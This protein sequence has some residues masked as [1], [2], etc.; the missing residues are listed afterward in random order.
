MQLRFNDCELDLQA[1][2]FRR[3]GQVIALEPQ[4]FELLALLVR[5]PD[6]LVDRDRIMQAV[7]N[8]RIVSD[9]AVSSRINAVRRAIGDDGRRQEML[10]TVPRLGFRFIAD[11]QPSTAEIPAT[12][13]SETQQI[14]M[15]R[16][17]DGAVLAYATTGSGPPLMRAGHFLTHVEQE[18]HSPV[19]RPLLDRL[20]QDFTL[21]RYDQ[22]CTGLSEQHPTG[23]RLD[24]FVEDMEAVA[25]AANLTRF[26]I[27]A[28]SQ[29]V[30]IALAFAA[31]H[32]EMVSALVL[33]GGYA[34][35]RLARSDPEELAHAEAVMT[36]MKHGWG[37]QG[38]AF[39]TAFATLYMPGASHDQLKHITE[40]Q[41]ASATPENA[42]ALR[43]A[44][45]CFDVTDRLKDIVAPTLVIRARDDAVHPHAQSSLLASQI[46]G[47]QFRILEG[48]N[49]V[50]LPQDPAWSEM[51]KATRQF[52]LQNCRA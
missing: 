46:S 45:D 10:Q 32:P 14:H 25:D 31:R 36:L 47:A 24:H 22:R 4:V 9:A 51:L 21:T 49:H 3:A 34:E 19:W 23:V 16:S 26:P 48:A 15:T 5:N 37:R 6:V 38:T 41:L 52:H 50:P 11:V 42:V 35:G 2:V 12:A 28:A 29:G 30:P 17:K 40:L 13:S 7:W 8:G 20:G 27:F 39:A 43:R 18:W 33:Y 1:H 44:V